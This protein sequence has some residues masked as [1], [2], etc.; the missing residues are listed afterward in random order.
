MTKVDLE[1]DDAFKF[2]VSGEVKQIISGV[3]TPI[4]ITAWDIRGAAIPDR[5]NTDADI[6]LTGTITDAVNGLYTFEMDDTDKDDMFDEFIEGRK[7]AIEF[8]VKAIFPGNT[9]GGTLA[10]GNLN[11]VKS[12]PLSKP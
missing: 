12:R 7:D 1:I 8:E 10:Q 4:D 3:E 11:L 5:E 9:G 6:V 2:I